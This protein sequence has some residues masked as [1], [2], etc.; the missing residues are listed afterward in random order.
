MVSRTL[1]T[2]RTVIADSIA[3]A[4]VE[5]DLTDLLSEEELVDEAKHSTLISIELEPRPLTIC[6]ALEEQTLR[7]SL[8]ELKPVG[9]VG[10]EAKVQRGAKTKREGTLW[11]VIFFETIIFT[12]GSLADEEDVAPRFW[13]RD[14]QP[15][16]L[17]PLK[18]E[19]LADRG[20]ARDQLTTKRVEELIFQGN[21]PQ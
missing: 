18:R 11:R 14:A 19:G 8:G 13:A 20:D 2:A 9:V 16:A 3:L 12:G 21:I 6:A 4:R 1:Y 5:F 15:A 17:S 7:V 10:A